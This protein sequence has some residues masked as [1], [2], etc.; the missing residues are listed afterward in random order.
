MFRKYS[1]IE[2]TF[3]NEFVEK[4]KSE[5]FGDHE[6]V[7]QEKAH[8]ANMSFLS[9]DGIHFTPAK[10]TD[11]LSPDEKFYNYQLVYDKY[12]ERLHSLWNDLNTDFPEMEQLNVFGELIGGDYAHPDVPKDREAIKVQ[13]GIYY[14]PS[15][16]FY[17]FDILVDNKIYLTSD[18]IEYYFMKHKFIYAKT[19]FRGSLDECLNYPNDFQSGIYQQFGL[20]KIESNVA[21]GVVIRPVEPC[22]LSG[23]GRVM[24]KNKNEKWAEKAKAKKRPQKEITFSDDIRQLQDAIQDYVTENRLNNVISKIGEISIKDMG[25]VLGLFAADIIEDFMKEYG[26]EMDKLEKKE[27]KLVTKSITKKSVEMVKKRL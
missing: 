2:N 17:A 18:K 14:C 27:Q 4:I 3:Q 16:E 24:L 1:S 11:V 10:R 12:L 8:G 20:P 7:V 25:N 5:G 22:F 19:L 21:E 23:G 26:R 6:Y 9:T 15:N 13:K